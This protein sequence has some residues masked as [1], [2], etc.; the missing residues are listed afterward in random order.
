MN[1]FFR[2]W[3]GEA[4]YNSHED[5]PRTGEALRSIGQ[6][7]LIEADVPISLLGRFTGLG[8]RVIWRHLLSHGF[9]TGEPW[10]HEDRARGPIPAANIVRFVLRGQPEFAVLTDCESWEPPL[11]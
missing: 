9:D 8:D 4:L 10:V 2:H 6:P 11:L 1:R 3:G 5:D 7:C